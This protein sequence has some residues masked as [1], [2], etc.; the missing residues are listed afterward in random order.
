MSNVRGVFLAM[1][2]LEPSSTAT[3]VFFQTSGVTERS[4][5]PSLK[6]VRGEQKQQL[7]PFRT[8]S[9]FTREIIWYI[10]VSLL[11]GTRKVC[12]TMD[13]V[14]HLQDMKG[15]GLRSVCGNVLAISTG[16]WI[17]LHQGRYL[18]LFGE[19]SHRS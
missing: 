12:G 8:S 7:S 1:R 18:H 17:L 9:S 19:R 15:K 10:A 4:K 5:D 6:V 13:K 14:Q 16:S 3:S 2:Q 11:T